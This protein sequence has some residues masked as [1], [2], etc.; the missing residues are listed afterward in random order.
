M[1][2]RE[3]GVFSNGLPYALARKGNLPISVV[4][5]TLQA[6]SYEDPPGKEGTSNVLMQVIDKGL[7]GL[8]AYE[9]AR[10]LDGLGA[11]L[12]TATSPFSLSITL[13]V[14]TPRLS[15]ALDLF[16][17]MLRQPALTDEE[18]ERAKQMIQ[19]EMVQARQEPSE[20]LQDVY[21]EVLYAG[22]PLHRP[23]EGYFST[24][25]RVSGEDVRSFHHTYF[26]PENGILVGVS[27]LPLSEFHAQLESAFGGWKGERLPGQASAIVRELPPLP[28]LTSPRAIVVN[29]DVNQAFVLM[30]NYSLRRKDDWYSPAR[31]LNYIY[32]GGGF[33][34]RLFQSIRNEKGYAYAVWSVLNPGRDLPGSFSVG[35]ETKTEQ[36]PDA[37][38][39]LLQIQKEIQQRGVKPRELKDAISYYRGS[40]ARSMQTYGQLASLLSEKVFYDLPDAFWKKEIEEIQQLRGKDVK[41]AAERLFSPSAYALALVIKAE[42]PPEI[43]GLKSDS[44]RFFSSV[45]DFYEFLQSPDSKL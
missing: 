10:A 37:L 3:Y 12:S 26:L 38:H 14:I 35:L 40:L 21:R 33:A 11:R 8:G 2:D 23:V 45:Y 30:G 43:S 6:G 1:K 24:L 36:F 22:H 5:I 25:S 31:V 44:I 7:E 34:S 13:Q 32:G 20:V 4:G 9:V 27:N 17:R 41:S 39:L 28:S 16:S 29:M 42:E 15:P 18:V 19:A